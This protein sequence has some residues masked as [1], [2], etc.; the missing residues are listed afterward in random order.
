MREHQVV[1]WAKKDYVS[2]DKT[3]SLFEMSYQNEQYFNPL[4]P[5]GY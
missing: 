3:M 2:R 1:L 5:G 4:M